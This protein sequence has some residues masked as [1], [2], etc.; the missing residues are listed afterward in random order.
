MCEVCEN[1]NNNNYLS[2]VQEW[3]EMER[4][5]KMR[6]ICFG[7]IRKISFAVK[8]GQRSFVRLHDK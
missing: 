7:Q 2:F 3:R 6:V 1:N 4:K 8:I 5:A